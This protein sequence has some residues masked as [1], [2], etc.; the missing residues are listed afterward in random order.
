MMQL[1]KCPLS[2][3]N[4]SMLELRLT[5]PALWRDITHPLLMSQAMHGMLEHK[6]E[7]LFSLSPPCLLFRLYSP[8]VASVFKLEVP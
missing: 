7:E 8:S 4:R 5:A 3:G 2:V 1:G 6:N